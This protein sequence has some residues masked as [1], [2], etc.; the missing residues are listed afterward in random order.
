MRYKGSSRLSSL[1]PGI[2]EHRADTSRADAESR[3]GF[4]V[5]QIG[6]RARA[7]VDALN[8]DLIELAAATAYTYTSRGV[9]R[10]SEAP[11]RI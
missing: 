5:M 10:D 11:M 1:P 6:S 8:F 2:Q 7:A 9:A 4:S 3:L